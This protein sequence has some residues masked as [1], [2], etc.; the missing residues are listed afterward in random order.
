M[1]H[2]NLT[3]IS[4]VVLA[5]GAAAHAQE[6][7]TLPPVV[8]VAS[9][10]IEAN[11]VDGFASF[12]TQV[13]ESQI[14]DLGALDLAAALRMTP[15]VQISRYNEVGSYSGDQGGNIYIRGIGA[16]RPGSEIK[17]LLDG[18]PVYMG[19]WNH[20]LMDLL[21][22]NGMQSVNILKGPQNQVNGNSFASVNLQSKRA[23]QDGLTGEI[24]TSFGSNAT[25]TL[26]GNLV[27]RKGDVDYGLAV[28]HVESNGA[29]PNADARLTNAMGHMALQ[30][31]NT[32]R[33]GVQ[34]L[35]V[36]NKAGDPGD[37]RFPTSNTPVGPYS[38]ANGV[39]RNASTTNLISA[40]AAH[41][42]GRDKGQIKVYQ[43]RGH[44]NLVND[45][46][47]GTFDSN[48]S[49]SG[50]RWREEFT[51]WKDGEFVGGIDHE[52]VSGSIKGPHVGAAVGT[53]FAFGMA[54]S[55][56][57]P[58]F[59]VT[60][61][62]AGISHNVNLAGGWVLKPSVG[63]RVYSS[64]RYA[65]KIA[66]NAGVSLNADN[67]TVYFNHT[68][69]LLY[70][71]AETYTLTRA[72]PMAFA[73]NNGWDR[74]S[75]TEDKHTE[76]GLRWSVSD[77]TQVDVSAFQDRISKRYVW[78]GFTPMASGAWS[79]GF[80][81]YR[82]SGME[83]SVKHTINREWTLFS[84]LTTLNPSLANLP[85]APKTAVS[86]GV[87]GLVGGY[88]IAVDAQHQ[89]SMFSVTQDRGSFNPTQVGSFTV[90]NM[91]IS[92]AL[93]A[94]GKS[95]EVY[96]AVNNLFDTSYQYNAGYPMPGRNFRVGM[97][98]SF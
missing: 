4:A 97:N 60:S 78:S 70:P 32:W 35:A 90:A 98:V 5:I 18:I 75:P 86:L 52:S 54:G 17:T 21:P 3:P 81:D 92:R 64:N 15:G 42:D 56:D 58:S 80:P 74:L 26:Q 40:V 83:A 31:N 57:I 68:N 12:S 88:R 82:V 27:G 37:N 19:L 76:I 1:K 66:P 29:R 69:A 11:H 43:N 87:T 22:L 61:A 34:F 79:N 65:S 85:Y 20:P 36:D 45:A 41:Q 24:N 13:S 28:G 23:T 71:G 96:L 46:N 25:R 73:A 94:L 62:Y 50:L 38:F 14:K 63:A 89:S 33:V 6:A 7:A 59:K 55:A 8:V 16:S 2:I 53:P 30:V 49:M 91:R 72:I 44:N 47:W 77:N 48:F 9:P 51:P 84:G 39:G 10:I 93:A 67:L 95:G